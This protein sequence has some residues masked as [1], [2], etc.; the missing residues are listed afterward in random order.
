MTS[1]T[2]VRSLVERAL[3]FATKAHEGQVRKYTNEPYINHPIAVSKLVA[4]VTDNQGMIAAALLHDTVEDTEVT[5]SDITREFGGIIS[6]WV[7]NLTDISKPE[8]GNRA[9]R[10]MID[11]RHTERSLPPAMTIKLADLIDNTG[12]IVEH[13]REFAKIYMNEKRLL[14]QVL[15][16]GDR[17]LYAQAKKIL[18]DYTAKQIK[19]D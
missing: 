13:D 8:D 19:H 7:E 16:H 9:A 11:L 6:E 1:Q 4:S 14:L 2:K 18:D 12:S 3:L 15:K 10:K 5:L 17:T